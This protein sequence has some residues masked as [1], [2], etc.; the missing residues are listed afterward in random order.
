MAHVTLTRAG[1]GSDRYELPMSPVIP[2]LLVT[3]LAAFGSYAL[4]PLALHESV[5][6]TEL[7][8]AANSTL[9][10]I[11]AVLARF[12]YVEDLLLAHEVYAD[13]SDIDYQAAYEWEPVDVPVISAEIS[14]YSGPREVWRSRSDD[15]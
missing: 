11:S 4:P 7:V 15:L 12:N 5:V 6:R 1:V 14:P 2:S 13:L 8:S 10:D 3:G 9:H